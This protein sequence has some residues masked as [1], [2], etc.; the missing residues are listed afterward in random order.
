MKPWAGIGAIF[1][2][3]GFPLAACPPNLPNLSAWLTAELVPYL[4]RAYA[5][6]RLPQLAIALSP[7]ET[8]PLPTAPSAEPP[9]QL[10][11]TVLTHRR[12]Q[13][14]LTQTAYWL[15]GQ[16]ANRWTLTATTP[17]R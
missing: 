16:K 17:A 15:F 10:F 3:W 13:R 7:T 4:N 14:D 9:A 8:E 12:G 11:A 5:Q 6:N 2:G 1:L